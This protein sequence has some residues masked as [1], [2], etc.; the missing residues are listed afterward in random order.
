MSDRGEQLRTSE[1]YIFVAM[2]TLC[3]YP[4]HQRLLADDDLIIFMHYGVAKQPDSDESVARKCVYTCVDIKS[5][6][7]AT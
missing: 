7:N 2:L 5:T 4:S 6:L 1:Y 3:G